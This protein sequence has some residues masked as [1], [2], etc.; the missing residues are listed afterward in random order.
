MLFDIEQY[1]KDLAAAG[2]PQPLIDKV[3]ADIKPGF[4]RQDD[5]SRKSQ[6]LQQQTQ[7]LQQERQQVQATYAQLSEYETWVKSLEQQY[8]PR[9]QWSTAFA[10]RVGASN[11]DGTG[12]LSTGM[13]PAEVQQMLD[14]ALTKQREE[15]SGL[16]SQQLEQVGHGAAQFSKFYYQANKYWEKEYGAELPEGDFQEF[17]TKNGH[18]NP[19]VAL[20]LF[21]MPFKEKKQQEDFDKRLEA[22]RLEGAASAR[23][24]AGIPEVSSGAGGWF[25]NRVS[26]GAAALGGT[27]NGDEPADPALIQSF[28]NALRSQAPSQSSS[29]SV[30]SAAV[31]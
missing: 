18:T 11:P 19:Q 5:Y 15:L 20:R 3:D 27:G 16:F 1:K 14:R 17:F 25:D 21:E 23:S 10:Q 31:K 9:E 6:I 4:M 8:G 7:T 13:S 29:T 24:Q 12:N 28:G 26:A 22:A 2:V 30:A